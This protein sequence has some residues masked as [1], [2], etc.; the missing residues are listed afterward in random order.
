NFAVLIKLGGSSYLTQLPYQGLSAFLETH[1]FH[2]VLEARIA[3]QVL[4]TLA[5][6]EKRELWIVLLN[7]LIQPCDR[8][9]FIT[10]CAVNN[11]KV[12]RRYP[13]SLLMRQFE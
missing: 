12:D 11:C 9:V 5:H 2:D 3:P 6:F 10:H 13:P 8:L 1:T 7:G 4:P